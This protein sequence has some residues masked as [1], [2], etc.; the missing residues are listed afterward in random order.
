MADRQ[1]TG[2]KA[3]KGDE[4]IRVEKPTEGAKQAAAAKVKQ[5]NH[6]QV[7][8][9]AQ[10][11]GID[12]ASNTQRRVSGDFG[13]GHQ[14]ADDRAEHEAAYRERNGYRHAR[15]QHGAPAVFAEAHQLPKV[16]RLH[17]IVH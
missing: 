8:N 16:D 12:V 13:P 15:K 1:H 10:Y 17:V 4:T 5:V 2:Q 6:Q 14:R 9:T 11:R 7:G 3:G